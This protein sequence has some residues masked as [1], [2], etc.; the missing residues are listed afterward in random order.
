MAALALVLGACTDD[1]CFDTPVGDTT[2]P[3]SLS[4]PYPTASRASDAGFE[5]GDR[6]GVYVL[7]YNGDVPQEITDEGA[8]ASNMAFTFRA[9][10]NSWNGAADIY[11]KDK[12]TP[13]DIIGYYPFTSTVSDPTALSHS[14]QRRQDVTGTEATLG[15]YESSDLLWGKVTKAM[16]TSGRVDLTLNHAMAAVRVTLKEG[17]GFGAGEWSE[18]EKAVLVSNIIPSG[19]VNL[20]TG[21]ATVGSADPISVTP[22]EYNG[23]FRA[24]VF[25]QTV[26]AGENLLAISADG[27]GYNLTKQEPMTYTAGKMHTFT[28]TVDKAADGSLE[29]SLTGEAITPWIDDVEFRDGMMRQYINV[30][31]AE[32]G[33]LGAVIASMGLDAS[34]IS[35]LKIKGSIDERD[36]QFIRDKIK[37]LTAINLHEAAVF[38][39]E[40]EAV[41]PFEALKDVKTLNHVIFPKKLKI[42]ATSAFSNTGLIGDLILPEG[43]THLGTRDNSDE[44]YMGGCPGPF[45]DCSSLV[46]TLSLPSTL[47]FIEGRAFDGSRFSGNLILPDGLTYIGPRAFKDNQFTGELHLPEKLDKICGGTFYNVPFTGSLVIP[48]NVK[49][50]GNGSDQKGGLGAFEGGKFTGSLILSEGLKKIGNNSFRYCGFKGEL[51]LPSTLRF[52]GNN[53]FEGMKVSSIVFPENISYIG[54]GAFRNCSRLTGTLILPVGIT[55]VFN[56]TFS[57]CISLEEVVFHEGITKIE[58]AAFMN[59]YNLTSIISNNPEPPLLTNYY[60][61]QNISAFEGVPKDNFTLQVPEKS[62][63]LYR[64]AAGWREFKRI[65]AYSNFVCRPATACA[66]N[67]SH[68]ETLV[69]NADGPW[70][71]SHQPD[72]VTLSK[73]S[74]NGKTEIRLTINEL[75]RNAGNREDYVEFSLTG[76]EFTTRCAISQYDYQYAEDECLTLQQATKGQRGIDILFVGEGFDGEAIT[77]GSYLD[78]VKEQMEAFFGIEPYMSYREYFNVYACISLSQETGINTDNLY[79][80]TRFNALYSMG[81]LMT[82]ND[83]AV[84]DYAVE[85]SPLTQERMG[86]SLV[87]MTINSDEYGSASS[88]TWNGSTIAML[89]RSSDPYPMDTRGVVQHEAC[90]HAFGKL[91]EERITQSRYLTKGEIDIIRQMQERGWYQ[92]I[93]TS[94]KM[95]DVSW[96]DFIFDTR[97]SDK[98]DI[99]EGGFGVTRGCF[100][101]EINTCMNYGIPYFSAPARMDIVRRILDYSGEGFT[102]EKFLAN[103]SDAWGPTARSRAAG[104]YMN[105]ASSYHYPVRIIKSKKY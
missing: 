77:S 9:A 29:F 36:F 42:I 97:Y 13:A 79:R 82:D 84:F 74:G 67:T 40:Q 59:C 1:V 12:T 54:K 89:S 81:K 16:P 11:W 2:L 92:N 52:I 58:S 43:L 8:R 31:V 71:V 28:V 5:E 64:S 25:P 27:D 48:Q 105:A 51:K 21:E 103:D 69:L 7:D 62:I 63:D 50:I 86:Q 68:E 78:L 18:M 57:E 75:A 15:G 95:S 33:T 45:G 98:V 93:S 83:D 66:L 46:G 99:F 96:R 94:G 10:D 76:K 19:T 53:A 85:H 30:E 22:V 91:G 20:T 47:I 37:Y 65:A 23:E 6:M 70:T 104:D 49:E 101:A 17:E 39:G 55:S 24:V 61:L 88:L 100:R 38:S 56:E 26:A 44:D 35:S 73:T 32:K 87:I 80:N 14:I 4:A 34:S 3:I 90:G 102:M 60:E 72:W 41:I